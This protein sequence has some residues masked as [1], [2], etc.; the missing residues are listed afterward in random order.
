VDRRAI[1][2]AIETNL[3]DQ[4]WSLRAIPSAEIHEDQFVRWAITGVAF[5]ALNPIV[6][7][8]IPSDRAD[9]VIA[10]TLARFRARGVPMLWLVT[11][12]SEPSDLAQRLE[13]HGLMCAERAPGMALELGALY[14]PSPA[15]DRIVRLASSESELDDFMDVFA[16]GF[17]LPQA[18]VAGFGLIFRGRDRDRFRHYVAYERDRAIAV[19]SLF[20]DQGVAGI[21][22]VTTLPE[23][24]GRGYG[25]AVTFAALYDGRAHGCH[26]GVLTSSEDGYSIYRKMGFEEYCTIG[27]YTKASVV[28]LS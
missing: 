18:A 27:T 9:Q 19:A 5:S 22:N 21:Y 16:K 25:S 10:E 15:T 1:V 20:R 4:I 23:A 12:S 26:L 13:A 6:R 7:T 2:A 17:D 14:E 3:C 24:R 11:P 8:A 28:P